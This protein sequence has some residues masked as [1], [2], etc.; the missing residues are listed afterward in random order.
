MERVET[1]I[2]GAGPAGLAMSRCLA[3]RGVEHVALERGRIAERWRSERWDSL[4]LLT[5]AWMTR[6]PGAEPLLMPPT[7]YASA[8]DVVAHLERYARPAPVV[9]GAAVE[10]ISRLGDDYL[11]ESTAGAWRARSVVLATGACDEPFV[12][13]M[14]AHLSARIHQRVP[15]R[16]RRPDDLPPGGVLVVGA[17]AAGTQLAAELREAGRHVALAVGAHTRMPRR[18]LG[19]DIYEWLDAMGTLDRRWHDTRDLRAARRAPSM[20]LVGRADVAVDLPSL[21]ARGVRLFGRL[22]GVDGTRVAFAD[23]LV[24][25]T[26]AAD[27]RLRRVL[28]RV[29]AFA[30]SLGEDD[31]AAVRP[32]PFTAP[33][34]ASSLDLTSAGITSV[35]WATGFRRRTAHLHLLVVG[36]DG[37]LVHHGGETPMPG[38]YALGL[39]FLRRRKSTYLDGVGADAR[40]LAARVVAHLRGESR[41]RAA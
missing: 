27:A 5:P 22:I 33:T 14:A 36:P 24:A 12:P 4:R 13:P 17:S 28:D 11:V 30:R 10:R 32:A 8:A 2:V 29:D 16:Y 18:H 41:T 7:S 26:R 21:Q 35:L 1:L 38:L 40:E 3:A 9:E 20:Q 39:P 23:D 31:A 19:R 15:T 25:T 6:L 37:E 34:S